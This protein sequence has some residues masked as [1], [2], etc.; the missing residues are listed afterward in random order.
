ML[1][2]KTTSPATS[3]SPAK[4]QPS[5]AAPSSRTSV[6]LLRTYS[7]FRS[8]RVMY[9][10]SANYSSH[11]PTRQGPSEIRRVRRTADQSVPI[12]RPPLREVN[13]REIR[14]RPDPEAPPLPD[15]AAGR[16]AHS[17][18]ET[19]EREPAAEDQVG[20]KRGE[21][22]LMAEK[23]RRGL[24]HR[25]LLLLRRVRRVVGSH[26]VEDAVAQGGLDAT[27]VAVRPEWRVDSVE[28]LKRRD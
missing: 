13:E 1:V 19:R 25:Q 28:P 18:H 26:E 17:L 3:P 11:H 7:K 20:I 14:H 4:L 8:S 24:L 10:L 27:A 2:V 15:P 6:A 12:H 16:T 22:R 21:G 23:P 9:Q 5:N